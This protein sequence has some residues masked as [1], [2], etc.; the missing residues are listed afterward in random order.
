MGSARLYPISVAV[1]SGLVARIIRLLPRKVHSSVLGIVALI[2][3]RWPT[4]NKSNILDDLHI[5]AGAALSL[6]G[7]VTAFLLQNHNPSISL[8]MSIHS[9]FHSRALVRMLRTFLYVELALNGTSEEKEQT[10]SWL[11]WI[12]RNIHGTITPEMR[13]TL[14]LPDGID[15]YGYIDD[16]KAYVVETLTWSTIAF[17]DRFGRRLSSRARD[18]IVLE[19]AC[20]GMRLGVPSSLL[21][22]NYDDFLVSITDSISSTQDA[23]SI[24]SS[25]AT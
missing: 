20:T 10:A 17:Q 2:R 1:P 6:I 4:F 25:Y 16:L 15:H 12:H 22:T 13:K 24:P 3:L 18:T 21:S 8:A 5:K 11:R 23:S 7:S 19:Y 9:D 14:G